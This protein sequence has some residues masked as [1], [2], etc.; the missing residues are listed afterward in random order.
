MEIASLIISII[1]TVISLFGFIFT[2]RISG[3]TNKIEESLNNK[4]LEQLSLAKYNQDRDKY[5]KSI[6]EIIE[7]KDN[8]AN[9]YEKII[10]L[11]SSLE[12]ILSDISTKNARKINEII[13]KLNAVIKETTKDKIQKSEG[14]IISILAKLKAYIS[15][16]NINLWG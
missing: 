5:L 16:S 4:H 13:E 15:S 7:E 1:G 11:Q 14:N 9:S 8:L 10:E 3:K 6:E 2:I 12:V